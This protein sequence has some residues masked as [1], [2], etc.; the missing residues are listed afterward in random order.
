MG[1]CVVRLGPETSPVIPPE[2]SLWLRAVAH[3]VGAVAHGWSNQGHWSDIQSGALVWQSGALVPWS[4]W[5]T[6]WGAIGALVG[7]I[8]GASLSWSCWN[9][10]GPTCWL[11]NPGVCWSALGQEHWLDW[12]VRCVHPEAA[13]GPGWSEAGLL[14]GWFSPEEVQWEKI[15]WALLVRAIGIGRVIGALVGTSG[16]GPGNQE[17]DWSEQSGAQWGTG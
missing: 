9:T 1:G 2:Y 5:G 13:L 14:G 7:A 16:I 17:E 6:G 15:S 4:R 3:W 11:T 12:G 8:R 10:G